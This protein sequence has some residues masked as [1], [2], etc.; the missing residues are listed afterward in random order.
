ALLPL[1]CS[2]SSS[3]G[4]TPQQDAGTDA[5]ACT[6]TGEHPAARSETFGVMDAK[7]RRLVFFGGD[8]GVPRQCQPA[9]APNGELWTYDLSCNQFAKVDFTDGP[10][11]RTR[12]VSIYDPEGDRMIVF[13][14]RYRQATAGAYT[15]YNEVWALDLAAM[16]WS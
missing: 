11:G 8:T 4:S 5:P 12:G 7:R 15:V 14:G 10:G 6:D 9:P 16:T 1:A 2:S 3:G 13:G